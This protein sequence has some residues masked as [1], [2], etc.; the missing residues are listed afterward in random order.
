MVN[1]TKIYTRTGDEGMT[2][3]SDF[4]RTRKTDPRI[5]AYADVDEANSALGVAISLA[6]SEFDADTL[7][8]LHQIQNE[9]F[10]L[11]AD[12]SNPLNEH[13]EYE[14]LRVDGAW[15]D[16]LEQAIDHYNTGLPTLD[17]FI[18]PGGSG[19][20]AG[21]HLA[22]TVVRRAE[23]ATWHAIETYGTEPAKKGHHDGGVNVLAV[24][25]L[26]RLSDLLFVLARVANVN[27]GGDVK[28]VPGANRRT[29]PLTRKADKAQRLE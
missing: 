22:R 17:S 27:H 9:L 11:G 26:N 28:W 18:L 24:R 5:E 19:L 12:L 21:L 25:Y 6:Q 8:L 3:L 10:D 1:L 4:S 15:I 29:T 2:G 20:A 23:R 13:Y 7:A 16:A 14:P